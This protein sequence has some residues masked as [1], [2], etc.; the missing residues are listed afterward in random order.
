MTSV[1]GTRFDITSIAAGTAALGALGINTNDNVVFGV[2][3][4]ELIV[5][6]IHG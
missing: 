2:C 5:F 1:T 4:N 3:G 6:R